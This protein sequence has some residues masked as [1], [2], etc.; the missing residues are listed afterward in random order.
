MV[1]R[2]GRSALGCLF[3]LLLAAVA[4]YFAVQVGDPYLKHLRYQDAMR[5]QIRFADMNSN[6]AITRRLQA[7]ADS[8]G[9]P[10]QAHRITLRRDEHR[11]H[12]SIS[13]DYTEVVEV[14]GYVR[15]FR[16]RPRAE[17]NY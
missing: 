9:L 13:A 12:I 7:S 2:P 11:R 8:L 14:P 5:Q 6:D 1:N 16:F 4:V 15:E 17:G 3:P 10:E